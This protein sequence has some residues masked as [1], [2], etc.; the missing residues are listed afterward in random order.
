MIGPHTMER[1]SGRIRTGRCIL[2][3]GKMAFQTVMASGRRLLPQ[4]RA[5]LA[6]GNEG[7]STALASCASRMVTFIRE[8]G[9]MDSFKIEASTRTAVVMS[10]LACGR[11]V[12]SRAV[13]SILQTVASAAEWEEGDAG[14]LSESLTPGERTYHPTHKTDRV[15]DPASSSYGSKDTHF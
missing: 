12:S 2:G 4:K 6:I 11:T 10:S 1:A 8:T 3:N 9:P 13:P 5:T 7:R 15:H 14:V